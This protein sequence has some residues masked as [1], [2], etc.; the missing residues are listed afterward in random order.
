[1]K[2]TS[3]QK[4]IKIG[5]SAGVTIPARDMKAAGIQAGDNVDVT[6]TKLTSDQA[7]T[8]VIQTAREIL[9]RYSQDF[10]NLSQR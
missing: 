4:V 9:E 3:V 7:D 6:I 8:D 5:S 10:T 1:M 2:I